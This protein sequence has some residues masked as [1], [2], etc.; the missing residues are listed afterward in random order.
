MK[1][2]LTVAEAAVLVGRSQRSIY[3]W[4]ESGSLGSRVE[5]DGSMRVRSADVR[6]AESVVRRG[7]PRDTASR[8]GRRE[9]EGNES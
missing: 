9:Q 2:W 6:R 4:V 5:P 8:N 7:R 3:R 1:E